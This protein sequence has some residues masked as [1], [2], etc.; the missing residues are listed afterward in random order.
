MASVVERLLALEER[1]ERV[2]RL[3]YLCYVETRRVA[4]YAYLNVRMEEDAESVKRLPGMRHLSDAE[5]LKFGMEMEDL[6]A[7]KFKH[8]FLVAR[9]R[10]D[11]LVIAK[12]LADE[13]KRRPVVEQEEEREEAA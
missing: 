13:R 10:R 11:A 1:L 9:C 6:V 5:A 12:E 8:R 2:E 4:E 7:L 3:S